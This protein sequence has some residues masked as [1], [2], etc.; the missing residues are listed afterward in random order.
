VEGTYV[1]RLTVTDD[2][3]ATATDD[4]QIVVRP[5][6]TTTSVFNPLDPVVTYNASSPPKPPAAGQVG[7]WVRTVRVGW[8][9]TSFKCYIYN[10]M[11]FRLKFPANYDAT[12]SYPVLIFFHGKNEY[13]SVLRQ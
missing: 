3:G 8:N 7:K 1:F 2:R 9:T 11:A 13:G 4:V 10:N 5:G 12:K 6:T